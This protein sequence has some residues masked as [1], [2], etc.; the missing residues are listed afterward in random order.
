LKNKID[1]FQKETTTNKNINLVMLTTYGI[2]PNEYSAEL[3]QN[4]LNMSCLFE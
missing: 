2:K 4:S 3:V 1:E